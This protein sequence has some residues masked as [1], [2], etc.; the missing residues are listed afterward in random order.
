[1]P[2][3]T[4]T[5]LAGEY[6]LAV[7]GLAMI[8]TCLTDPSATAPRVDEIRGIVER[9]DEFPNSLAIPMSE[10]DVEDGYTR[11][12]PTYDGPN[13]AIETEQPIVHAMLDDAPRGTALDAA[14][15][16]GRHA[17][18]LAE[19]GYRVI[20]I[21]AID[22]MLAVAREKVPTAEFRLGRLEQLPL[23]DAS[24]DVVTCALALTHVPELEPVLREVA[25][26]L[27]PGGQA[28]LSDIHPFATMTGGIAGFPG[29]D[30]TQGIP[31]V[32]NL[33]HQVG[34]YV[35]AFRAVGLSILDC[36]E[37]RV[38]EAV[39]PVLPSYAV[40]PEAT[41]QAYLDTP[42]LLIWRL[43]REGSAVG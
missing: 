24:V 42:Y 8:R 13:P 23:D 22:A 11:W 35:A 39:L 34:D 5:L 10:H 25:R 20:G 14:C 4:H 36:I 7:E 2:R 17:A 12:A 28:I 18:A 3:R 29:A 19:R 41:R 21:D 15:G 38:G 43:E 16:T 27:R 6:F 1:M 40:L 37:P 33:T 32:V 30:I 26:I 9:F 31:Y